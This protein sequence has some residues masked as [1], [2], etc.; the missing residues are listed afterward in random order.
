MDETRSMRRWLVAHDF[1]SC[2][3][4]AARITVHDLLESGGGTLVLCHVFQV[5]PLPIAMDSAAAA[6]GLTALEQTASVDAA[7]RLERLAEELRAEL[8]ALYAEHPDAPV[9]EIEIAVRQAP[10]AEGIVAEAEARG[11]E[12][13]TVGSHGRRGLSHLFLGSVAE[14][15]VRLA[16]TPV[17]VVKEQPEHG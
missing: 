2:A 14:K 15:V 5:M 17:L 4:A 8:R 3:D 1:T 9:V 12:R 10:P 11:A 7:R 16:R 13:I 6:A